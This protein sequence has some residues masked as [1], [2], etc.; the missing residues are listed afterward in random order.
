MTTFLSTPAQWA[1]N[2]FGFAQMGDSR[3]TKRLV[4]IAQH[5]AASP[6][7]T[8]PQAFPQWA[9]LKAAYLFLVE[10]ESALSASWHPT[11]NARAK[12]AV[13]LESIC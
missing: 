4:N 3:R 9:E 10:E 12:L 1:Q 8:L 5:L 2:E 11:W 6:G 13:S 7:G